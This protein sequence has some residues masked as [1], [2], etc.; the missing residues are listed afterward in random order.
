MKLGM[1]ILVAVVFVMLCLLPIFLK[2]KKKQ[3]ELKE[4]IFYRL[5]IRSD[6][7]FHSV[8]M[9]PDRY[10]AKDTKIFILEYLLSVIAQ[11]TRADYTSGFVSKEA[12]IV[13]ILTELKLGHKTATKERIASQEQLDQIHNALQFIIRAMRNISEGY[14]ASRVMISQHIALIRYAHSLAYRDLL[15]RQ[16][17]QDLDDDRKNRA[18]EKYRTALSVMER[19]GSVSGSKREAVRLQNMIQDVENVL[20]SKK[21]EVDLKSK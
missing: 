1:L 4:K 21:N 19:N 15:V 14:G 13:R 18:L 5:S 12:D 16:A 6:H 20:F 11:L 10:L 8:E 3:R 9:I 17:R 2:W 7:L